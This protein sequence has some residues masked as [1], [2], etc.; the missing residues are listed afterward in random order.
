MKSILYVIWVLIVFLSAFT[1]GCV[2]LHG[3]HTTFDTDGKV[4]ATDTFKYNRFGDQHINGF[5]IDAGK[6]DGDTVKVSLEGQ[7][8]E[9]QALSEAA[10]ALGNAVEAFAKTQ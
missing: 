4:V 6:A 5:S 9:A 8:S 10:Q 7:A 3:E 1:S 2:T